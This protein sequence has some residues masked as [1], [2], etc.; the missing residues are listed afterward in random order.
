MSNLN[1]DDILKLTD[2]L[3]RQFKTYD[4]FKIASACG[5]H[6]LMRNDFSLQKGAFVLVSRNAFLLLNAQL[7][8]DTLKIVCAHELG[9]A[10][11]HRAIANKPVFLE[12]DFFASTDRLEYE[13]NCFAAG[14]LLDSKEIL[15]EAKE[16]LDA[17]QIA[18]MHHSHV[19]LVLLL[20]QMNNQKDSVFMLPRPVKQR[21]MGNIENNAGII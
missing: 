14:L 1:T 6:V 10:L 11:M 2:H 4:P 20:I 3:H 21:F 18:R 19:N 17:A 12:E 9:H 8:E 7:P 13:A 16:G 15:S 5:I